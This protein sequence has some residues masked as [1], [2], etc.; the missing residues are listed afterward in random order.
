MPQ[1]L[2]KPRSK[3]FQLQRLTRYFMSSLVVAGMIYVLVPSTSV[4]GYLYASKHVSSSPIQ[5]PVTVFKFVWN[6][7][8]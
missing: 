5:P 2:P 6:P 1:I 8:W 3:R 7:L 4:P